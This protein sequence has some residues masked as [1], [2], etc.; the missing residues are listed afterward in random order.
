MQKEI[1]SDRRDHWTTTLVYGE[2]QQ[3]IEWIVFVEYLSIYQWRD[4]LFLKEKK[5]DSPLL[6]ALTS[7]QSIYTV[8]RYFIFNKLSFPQLI[9]VVC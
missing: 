5:S 8:S 4:I 1:L 3:F 9:S 2:E 7:D 6:S